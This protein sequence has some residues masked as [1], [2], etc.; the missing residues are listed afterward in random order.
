MRCC[1]LDGA[2]RFA[3]RAELYARARPSYPDAAVS[4][5]LGDASRV[6]DAGAGTAISTRL[7]AAHGARVTGFDPSVEMVLAARNPRLVLARAEALPFRDACADLVT[8]FNA[9]HWFQPEPF[10]ED[11]HRVLVPRGR[12]ALV[13]NDWDRSDAFTREFVR[14]MRSKAA[15]Y[16]PEDREAECAPLYATK[17][18][19][20]VE[21]R[22]FPNEHRLDL[23]H[24]RMRLQSMTYI[25]REGAEWDELSRDLTR[26]FDRYADAGGFVTH[27]YKTTVFVAVRV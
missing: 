4:F 9:F 8:S 18:F 6:I 20:N 2:G 1:D 11:A 14:L 26:L 17:R 3:D 15:G 24:L 23:E 19:G 27:H 12:L 16:P 10:F 7:L 5:V 21:Y 22:A 13:W 25:P